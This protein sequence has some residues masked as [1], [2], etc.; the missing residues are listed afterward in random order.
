[1]FLNFDFW[2]FRT[3][4]E[5]ICDVIRLWIVVLLFTS[6]L[7]SQNPI[8]VMQTNYWPIMVIC[9]W[10][11]A[12]FERTLSRF[13]LFVIPLHNYPN[14]TLE[15]SFLLNNA[16]P[17]GT[18][19]GTAMSWCCELCSV[20]SGEV[21][22]SLPVGTM[23]DKQNIWH[24]ETSRINKQHNVLKILVSHTQ[25]TICFYNFLYKHEPSYLKRPVYHLLLLWFKVT[26]CCWRG[27]L[28]W[29]IPSEINQWWKRLC[30]SISLNFNQW[31]KG[32]TWALEHKN[33]VFN[34]FKHM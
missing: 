6:V 1:M 18:T 28:Y 25:Y 14:I 20:G 8:I 27:L 11:S 23:S 10:T 9:R 15:I 33:K 24:R 13:P 4:I 12:K 7:K 16:W 19:A 32:Y 17:W 26:S 30:L 31:Q 29:I 21:P 22:T 2:A 3:D 5:N 34:E